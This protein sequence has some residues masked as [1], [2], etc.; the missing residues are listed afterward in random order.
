MAAIYLHSLR[1]G[2]IHPMALNAKIFYRTGLPITRADLHICA[3]YIA[4]TISLRG[5]GRA[6]YRLCVWKWKTGE[7]ILVSNHRS[8]IHRLLN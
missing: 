7:V 3:S 5:S 1:T 6:Q 2:E 4:L 8:C